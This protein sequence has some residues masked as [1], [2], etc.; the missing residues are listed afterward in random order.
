MNKA[1]LFRYFGTTTL[2][3][4]IT[5]Y[6]FAN[7]Q[8]PP[9]SS[10]SFPYA[11]VEKVPYSVDKRLT[12]DWY[13]PQK[14]GL[15][16]I[17]VLVHGGAFITG[18]AQD[19]HV[20]YLA[21]HFAEKGWICASIEYRL[22]YRDSIYSLH[23]LRATIEAVQDLRTFL[24][25]LKYTA[26][27]SN[28]WGIDTNRIVVFGHSAGA[29]TVYHAAFC[30]GIEDFQGLSLPD[31][32]LKALGDLEGTGYEGHTSTFWI[33]VAS[34]GGIFHPRYIRKGRAEHLVIMHP[35]S[36]RTVPYLVGQE[37]FSDAKWYGGGYIDSVFR[38][39]GGSTFLLNPNLSL[40]R[41][42]E[43]HSLIGDHK[44]TG[45][46]TLM[47]AEYLNELIPYLSEGKS[48]PPTLRRKDIRHFFSWKRCIT[49][50]ID[51]EPVHGDC[52][53]IIAELY[54]VIWWYFTMPYYTIFA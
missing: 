26:H 46:G 45:L 43:C 41:F 13:I 54:S 7:K 14:E 10:H 6:W 50:I 8:R 47:L 3:L 5:Y 44:Y 2:L 15:K 35:S 40:C 4:G 39:Q 51:Y 29:V 42:T 25:Y 27:R 48:P 18:S 52:T 21:R 30:Q 34:S 20:V 53:S 31:S 49:R 12:A 19:S 28:P 23:A 22:G 37:A 24:R 16:P 11:V 32:T 9:L 17:L 36:E 38:K 33:A 1:R